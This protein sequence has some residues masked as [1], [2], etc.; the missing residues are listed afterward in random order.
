MLGEL[1][2][3]GRVRFR[4]VFVNLFCHGAEGL[5]RREGGGEKCA[6]F[7]SVGTAGPWGAR[8]MAVS[9]RSRRR[10]HTKWRRR[11][12][13]RSATC[14]SSRRRTQNGGLGTPFVPTARILV[15]PPSRP[16]RLPGFLCALRR[17]RADAAIFRAPSATRAPGPPTPL[18]ALGIVVNSSHGV[19]A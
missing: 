4:Q 15:H 18:P 3:R 5:G 6:R 14:G 9:A 10:A 12:K 11:H 1:P 17:D 8:K 19:G 13:A 16:C 2:K 7:W